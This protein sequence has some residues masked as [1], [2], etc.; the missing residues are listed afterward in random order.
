[1]QYEPQYRAV[2]VEWTRYIWGDAAAASLLTG[3]ASSSGINSN[4]SNVNAN[5][6]DNTA[7][8]KQ[9]FSTGIDITM[10]DDLADE[11]EGI[12]M[13]RTSTQTGR[14]VAHSEFQDEDL[15]MR[16]TE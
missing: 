9:V 6:K 1:M 3:Q 11:E 2:R 4:V 7:S 16:N 5:G 13:R 12:G 10:V 8:R 14:N 15:Q